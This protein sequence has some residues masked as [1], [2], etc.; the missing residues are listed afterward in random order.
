[1]I[2]PYSSISEAGATSLTNCITK[3]YISS[4]GV[5]VIDSSTAVLTWDGSLNAADILW[6]NTGSTFSSSRQQNIFVVRIDKDDRGVEQQ[7]GVLFR[8][9]TYQRILGGGRV[10]RIVSKTTYY[11]PLITSSE[12]VAVDTS[13]VAITHDGLYSI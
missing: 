7:F 10:K 2:T 1:M 4:F 9:Y 11:Y 3:P 6:N 5:A 13:S 12:A 8:D